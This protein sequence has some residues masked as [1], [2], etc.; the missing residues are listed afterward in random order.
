LARSDPDDGVMAGMRP[1]VVNC[2]TTGLPD[3]PAIQLY[4]IPTDTPFPFSPRPVAVI[5][6]LRRLWSYQIFAGLLGSVALRQ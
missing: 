5:I 4:Y 6:F 1:L 2:E 3:P